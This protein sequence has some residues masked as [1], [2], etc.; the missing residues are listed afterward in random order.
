MATSSILTNVVIN[1]QQSAENFLNALI[2]SEKDF[3]N[4]KNTKNDK[5]NIKIL[6]Q[7]ESIKNLFSKRFS[8]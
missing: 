4:N 7:P 5:D 8:K 3:E 2:L 6:T 1:N